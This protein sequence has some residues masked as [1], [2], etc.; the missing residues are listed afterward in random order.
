MENKITG[1]V[2]SVLIAG[3][4]ATPV[5][6]RELKTIQYSENCSAA[7]SVGIN[8]Y[9]I[10]NVRCKE[11]SSEINE[12]VYNQVVEADLARDVK[13]LRNRLKPTKKIDS[14][15]WGDWGDE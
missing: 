9:E 1:L 15:K 14:S 2:A 11:G 12:N 4:I 5:T 13:E 10:E 7:Y 3:A 8:G 6:A